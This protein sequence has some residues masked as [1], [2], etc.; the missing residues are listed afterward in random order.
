MGRLAGVTSQTQV[1]M[2]VGESCAL[3]GDGGSPGIHLAVMT[4]GGKPRMPRVCEHCIS[5]FG[6]VFL[7]LLGHAGDQVAAV[8]VS[9]HNTGHAA[10]S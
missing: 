3:C 2:A 10:I 8:A 9:L 5:A 7:Q 6:S 4:P 1:M